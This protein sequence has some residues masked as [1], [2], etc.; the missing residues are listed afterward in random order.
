MIVLQKDMGYILILM[1]KWGFH[2]YIVT[3]IKNLE[4]WENY[5][6]V[7]EIENIHLAPGWVRCIFQLSRIWSIKIKGELD[8]TINKLNIINVVWN[9]EITILNK[10]KRPCQKNKQ[11]EKTDWSTILC[12]T[13]TQMTRQFSSASWVCWIKIKLRQQCGG[14]K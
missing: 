2:S 11:K 5:Y 3:L 1:R 4:W 9:Q 12:Q 10:R 14:P 6:S 13:H 7:L 8:R